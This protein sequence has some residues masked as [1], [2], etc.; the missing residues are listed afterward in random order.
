MRTA[1]SG[2]S[3]ERMRRRPSF[4]LS[5]VRCGKASTGWRYFF[6]ART[7]FAMSAT[8]ARL[9]SGTRDWRR[10]SSRARQGAPDDDERMKYSEVVLSVVEGSWV[11]YDAIELVEYAD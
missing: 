2:T 7:R 3:L 8:W 11:L 1:R 5:M 9:V 6:R 4:D 10:S